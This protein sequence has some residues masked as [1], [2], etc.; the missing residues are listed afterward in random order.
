M[1]QQNQDPQASSTATYSPIN[2]MMDIIA[3]PGQ[4]MDGVRGHNGWMWWPLLTTFIVSI[5][6]TVFY[7]L[8]VDFPWLI[9][10]TIRAL[11]PE[12]TPETEDAVRDFMSPNKQAMMGA[13]GIVIVTFLIYAIQSVYLNLVTKMTVGDQFKFGDWFSFSVWTGFV[14]IFNSI[15]MLGVLLSSSTNQVGQ[16]SLLPL[17]FNTLFIHAAPGEPWFTW[18][19]SLTLVNIWMLALMAIGYQRWTKASLGKSIAVTSAPWVALFGVWAL[20]ISG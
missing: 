2:A 19:N 4:A 16:E 11:P 17:S 1:E 14:G 5:G 6:A 15:I 10:E 18:G 20:T 3:A 7:A 9:E 13:V 12:S 8:W